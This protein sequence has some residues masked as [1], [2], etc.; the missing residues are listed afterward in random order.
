MTT[1][2]TPRTHSPGAGGGGRVGNGGVGGDENMF[3]FQ[4]QSAST[5]SHT[6]EYRSKDL[7]KKRQHNLTC[8]F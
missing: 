7:S 5:I 6:I 8:E 2:Y 4:T 1:D 3:V